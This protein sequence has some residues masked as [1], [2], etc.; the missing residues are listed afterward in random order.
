MKGNPA[1]RPCELSSSSAAYR[2]LM[3][4]RDPWRRGRRK[5]S[6]RDSK[7]KRLDEGRKDDVDV[8]V[9]G[10]DLMRVLVL[11]MVKLLSG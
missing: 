10:E 8:D 5:A 6:S 9:E 4:D 7:T 3:G 2:R 1:I 11:G